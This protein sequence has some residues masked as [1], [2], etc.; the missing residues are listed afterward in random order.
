MTTQW[1][2]FYL[3]GLDVMDAQ[4]M[5]LVKRVNVLLEAMR[6]GRG[7]EEVAVLIRFLE[8][9][10]VEHFSAEERLMSSRPEIDFSTHKAQH[11]FLRRALANFKDKY[12]ARGASASLALNL[13]QN[14]LQWLRNHM[15]ITDKKFASI[16]NG[17]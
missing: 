16:F 2:D 1:N 3:M 5:E 10:A 12:R 7:A 13:Q 4:H 6:D 11:H 9:Y 14:L 17:N 15:M 8:A